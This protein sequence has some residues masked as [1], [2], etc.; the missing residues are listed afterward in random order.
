MLTANLVSLVYTYLTASS[1]DRQAD[2]KLTQLPTDMYSIQGV[3][4][5]V[6]FLTTPRSASRRNC[7]V[8]DDRVHSYLWGPAVVGIEV[9][10]IV[11]CELSSTV[12]T[13][14]EG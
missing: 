12:A 11:A 9:V 5:L 13:Y 4:Y 8:A 2:P 7:M 1:C 10:G 3:D 14:H 6:V